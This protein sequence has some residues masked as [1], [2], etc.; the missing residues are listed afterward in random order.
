[1]ELAR[2]LITD[3]DIVSGTDNASVEK[4]ATVLNQYMTK[5]AIIFDVH[6]PIK[7]FYFRIKVI[8]EDITIRIESH[9]E[10]CTGLEI[11]IDR[12]VLNTYISLSTIIAC[13]F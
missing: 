1:M 2:S 3:E 9:S 12:F 8:L 10:L 13:L 11:H 7:I 6:N 4:W 5:F